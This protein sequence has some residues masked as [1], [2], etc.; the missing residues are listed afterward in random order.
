[1]VI[2][3]FFPYLEVA[4]EAR[5]LQRQDFA[6]LDTGFD[7]FLMIPHTFV[8]SLGDPDFVSRS[9]LG[10][11]SLTYGA[12]FPG[13]IRIVG[14]GQAMKG[15]ITCLGNDWILGLGILNKFTVVFDHGRTVN[16]DE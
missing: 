12:D 10:D 2:S 14:L 1:M 13:E 8:S 15:G 3:D 16:I 7:G 4:F 9:E 5:G 6:Y 11:S